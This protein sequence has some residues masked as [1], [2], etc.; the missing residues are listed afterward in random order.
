MS[1]HERKIPRRKFLQTA[2]V[3]GGVAALPS[4]IPAKALGRDG[5]VPASERIVAGGIGIGGRGQGDV[6]WMMGEPDVQF[7]AVCDARKARREAVKKMVDSRNGN[8]DCKTYPEIREFLALRTDLDAVLI[9]TSDRWHALASI[10]AM[11]AGKDVYSEKPS[12]MTIAEGQAVVE[13]ANRYGRIYQTGVQRLSE[14]NFVFCIETARSGRLGKVHTTYA[15][16]APWDAAEMRHDWLPAQPEPPKEELDWDLWLGPCPW[17][18]YNASYVGGGWHGQYD[19]HTSCIGEWGAHTFAQAQA[20]IDALNTSPVKYQYVN[21]PTGDE[22]VTEFASG[23]KMVLSRGDKYW[24]GS[25]GMRFDG[26][27]GWVSA[28][29]GYSK[30]EVSNPALLA[31]FNKV[32]R[33]YVART[34]NA[35]GHMRN[36]LDCVKSRRPTVANPE[37]MHRSMSTVHAANI[38]MWLKRD[39][40]YDPVKEEFVGDAEANR[41][42]SR[43]MR[44]PWII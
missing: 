4:L 32:V 31:D 19:F 42:R 34:G 41:L 43:A 37:V 20:G 2:A 7:V 21:N 9:A 29:D 28:A 26:P 10:L 24:R 38:C 3:A 40:Q 15:H 5:A 12:S 17:R 35:M 27:E 18:P 33:D 1:P 8:N 39:V 14:P 11:R 23:V 36:F 44:E 16:I 22:M 25:C 30:P 6:G 13:T